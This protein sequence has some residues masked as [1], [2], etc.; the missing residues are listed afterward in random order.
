MVGLVLLLAASASGQDR[1]ELLSGDV[2]IGHIVEQNDQQV[3]LEHPDL[4]QLTIVRDRIRGMQREVGTPAEAAQTAADS[5]SEAVTPPPQAAM[6]AFDEAADE[7]DTEA[8]FEDAGQPPTGETWWRALRRRWDSRLA[9]RFDGREANQTETNLRMDF[10]TEKRREEDRWKLD[11]SYR[12]RDRTDDKARSQLASGLLH[13]AF[14][15]ATPWSL[16]NR[17]R[18]EY[19]QFREWDYRVTAD[20]SVG[21][22]LLDSRA[23]GLTGRFGGGVLGESYP[24]EDRYRPEGLLGMD[25]FLRF[26]GGQRITASV[27]YLPSLFDDEDYRLLTSA[28]WQMRIS[29]ADGLS[30][31]IGVENEY[32]SRPTDGGPLNDLR[33]YGALVFEF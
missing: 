15:P 2:L 33:Y 11:L 10:E 5:E 9:V 32:E 4:G 21:Y 3:V 16:Q 29:K 8:A 7:A 22:Q 31:R 1:I 12:L 13:E 19:D 6:P 26:D 18:Y 24:T 28:V 20:T 23:L 25:A 27:L 17:A 30:L 14:F